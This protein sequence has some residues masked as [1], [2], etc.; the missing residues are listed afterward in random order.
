[1]CVIL[2]GMDQ[3][4]TNLPDFNSGETLPQMTV[5]IIGAIV[6]GA[7]KQ[8]YTY[9][10]TDFTKETNTNLEVL[11]RVVSAQ[12]AKRQLP[13][14]LV[15]Q[16]DNTWQKNKNSRFFTYVAS[17]VE[18]DVFEEIIVNFLPIC[19]THVRVREHMHADLN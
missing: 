16:V 2:D 18:A 15:I 13:P 12:R 11:S 19:H 10:V 17:L 8:A 7:T 14:V 5:R 3:S 4:K 6:H 9:L 1:M